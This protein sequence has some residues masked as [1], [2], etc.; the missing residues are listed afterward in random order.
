MLLQASII[1]KPLK[2]STQVDAIWQPHDHASYEPK[3][4]ASISNRSHNSG[5]KPSLTSTDQDTCKQR[6]IADDTIPCSKVR[7]DFAIG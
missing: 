5:G 6:N 4:Y 3:R 1:H 7:Q 2:L